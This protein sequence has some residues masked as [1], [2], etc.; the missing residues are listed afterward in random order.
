MLTAGELSR[1]GHSFVDPRIKC[2]IAMSP[3]VA[4]QPKAY[5][6]TYADINIPLFVMTGTKDDS[7]VGETKAIQRR[8][9]FDHVKLAPAYLLTLTGGDH[10][11]FSG[12]RQQPS[13]EK[14][15]NLVCQGSVA[16][17]DA[18]LKK[19]DSAKAWLSDGA[20]AKALGDLGKFEK[21]N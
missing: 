20:Y 21:K 9:P 10:M 15:E 4:V 7:P 5:A 11:V 6:A 14:F 17:W 2:A 3:P 16:F 8:V 19:D 1:S 18:Y 12:R 13:D